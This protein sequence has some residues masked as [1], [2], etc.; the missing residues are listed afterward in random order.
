MRVSEFIEFLESLPP[1]LEV[2]MSHT[3][4]YGRDPYDP[5]TGSSAR[6][7]RYSGGMDRYGRASVERREEP[8]SSDIIVL[9]ND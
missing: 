9:S 2:W 4:G 5:T 1:E 6:F 8:E 3:E 7:Y